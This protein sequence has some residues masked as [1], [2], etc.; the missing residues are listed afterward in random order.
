M[1]SFRL[2]LTL[3][4]TC[5]LI[6]LKNFWR[7]GLELA[8]GDPKRVLD[9]DVLR[10]QWPSIG[11]G[12]ED[13]IL[14]FC[15]AMLRQTHFTDRELVEQ[16]LNSGATI[17]VIVGGKDR[18]VSARHVKRFFQPYGDRIQIEEM[19]G[20]GH[21]PFEEDTEGFLSVLEHMLPADDGDVRYS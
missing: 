9:G 13:G 17:K 5:H 6:S 12:W 10:F 20:L 16:V 7:N 1:H 15:T 4:S 2:A 11:L 18:V 19:E 21:D 3:P 14:K 8:W